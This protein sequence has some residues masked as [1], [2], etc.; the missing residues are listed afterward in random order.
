MFVFELHKLGAR[1]NNV[2]D[3]I[4]WDRNDNFVRRVVC[5]TPL[6][7]FAE[8]PRLLFYTRDVRESHDVGHSVA[9]LDAWQTGNR[10]RHLRD[11]L[12]W[13]AGRMSRLVVQPN[14]DQQSDAGGVSTASALLARP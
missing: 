13:E 10:C 8:A 14:V 1:A 6:R 9:L 4:N 5:V 2:C 7:R 3:S 12:L 11:R